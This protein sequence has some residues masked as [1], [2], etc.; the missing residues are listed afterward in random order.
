MYCHS[1]DDNRVILKSISGFDDCQHDYINA[2]YVDV[3][4]YVCTHLVT[5]LI[6]KY[7]CRDTT[8]KMRLLLPKVCDVHNDLCV[9]VLTSMLSIG[10]LPH[11]MID[12]WR[13][14]WQEQVTLIIMLCNTVE[15]HRVRCQQYW[16]SSGSQNYG[17]FRIKLE[18]KHR[19]TDYT[20]RTFEI[21]VCAVPHRTLCVYPPLAG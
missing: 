11:T 6:H 15:G 10:P 5:L 9:R 21:E 2:S 13:M 20:L 3:S 14:V 1:D 18:T 16:P 17:P 12:F 7:I 4:H 8:F 19:F